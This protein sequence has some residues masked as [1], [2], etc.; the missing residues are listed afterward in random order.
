MAYYNAGMVKGHCPGKTLDDF[1]MAAGIVANGL[2]ANIV[3]CGEAVWSGG[4]R[5]MSSGK[6]ITKETEAQLANPDVSGR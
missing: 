4:Q 1:L 5:V 2:G 3:V 6:D